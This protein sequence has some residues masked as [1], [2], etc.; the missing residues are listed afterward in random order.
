MSFTENS[1][2]YIGYEE[3]EDNFPAQQ[4]GKF[5]GEYFFRDESGNLIYTGTDETAWYNFKQEWNSQQAS[6]SEEKS[7]DGEIVD[8][9]FETTTVV[10][11]SNAGTPIENPDILANVNDGND[12]ID[13][14]D[15]SS[16]FSTPDVSGNDSLSGTEGANTF[17]INDG[18]FLIM[19]IML[20]SILTQFKMRLSF[21]K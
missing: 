12:I 13:Q 9:N 3:Q 19:L 20:A 17:D 18:N 11:S 2:E 4:E 6:K 21:L 8:E 5:N 7:T 14:L 10:T 15:F 16:Q 1:S